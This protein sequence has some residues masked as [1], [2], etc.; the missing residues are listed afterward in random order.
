MPQ[1]QSEAPHQSQ[2]TFSACDLAWLFAGIMKSRALLM[3]DFFL[4]GVGGGGGGGLT[5]DVGLLTFTGGAWI[6][7]C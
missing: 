5:T 7:V 4:S 2:E 3:E 6:K 1:M